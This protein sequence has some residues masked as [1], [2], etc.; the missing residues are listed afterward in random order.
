MT[1][2]LAATSVVNLKRGDLFDV[3]I[4][5]AGHGYDGYFGNPFNGPYRALNIAEFRLWFLKRVET[6]SVFRTRVLELR[7][8]RLGC[9]CAPKPCHGNVIVDWLTAL[10]TVL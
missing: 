7:G 9:F 6:D 1:T 2:V 5:R 8:K 3:Y 10:P 4:G